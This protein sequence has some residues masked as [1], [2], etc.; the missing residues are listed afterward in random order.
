M[1]NSQLKLQFQV[2]L[3]MLVG[4]IIVGGLVTYFGRLGE[5]FTRF[6][7][8]RV[9]Y[10]NASGLL[11]GADVLM[12]GARIG[13]VADGPHILPDMQGVY[14]S[15]KIIDDVEIPS[16]SVFTIGSSGLLGDR[17]VDITM[18][19]GAMDSEPI[20]RGATVEGRRETGFGE[21]AQEGGELVAEVREAVRNINT[22]VTRIN[23]EL[24][25]GET[26]RDVGEAVGGLRKTS[27][28]LAASAERVDALIVDTSAKI[29]TIATQA[30][31]VAGKAGEVMDDSR[32]M[33]AAAT[34][35]ADEIQ[36]AAS[37]VRA[38]VRDARQG[39]GPLAL[40]LHNQQV[41]ENLRALVA[42]LRR[43]GILWYRDREPPPPGEE[44]RG[45]R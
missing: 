21:I 13:R 8:I 5:G 43:H 35:A 12:A 11:R 20:P 29:N 45:R 28:A 34:K 9:E 18:L 41:A 15:L 33:I 1:N 16:A 2:G 24:L 30:E 37:D 19:P 10:P 27:Q 23:T 14:V 6:Y 31:S 22:V 26:L 42:N 4:L 3:F 7:E 44:R 36:G 38:V 25:T 32:K 17:F 40:L 39:D